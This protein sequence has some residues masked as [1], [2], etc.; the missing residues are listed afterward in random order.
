MWWVL[1]IGCGLLA[2]KGPDEVTSAA[3]SSMEAKLVASETRIAALEQ[4]LAW[5]TSMASKVSVDAAGNV[6]FSGTNIVLHNG[7]GATDGF[8][9][10]ASDGSDPGVVDGKGNLLVGYG[11]Q[12]SGS[13]NV[14]VGTAVEAVS[15]GALCAGSHSRCAAPYAAVMGGEQ[16]RA[17]GRGSVVVMGGVD[18]VSNAAEGP[19]SVVIGGRNNRMRAK[20]G[21]VA[22]GPLP[23][24]VLDLTF[25]P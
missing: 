21:V 16:G 12:V 11:H 25:Y 1:L 19:G 8:A 24:E 3:L 23:E 22:V 10:D 9:A 6:V 7:R 2:K 15:Y 20:G 4:Q 14:V 18:G 5:V 13:H 17:L